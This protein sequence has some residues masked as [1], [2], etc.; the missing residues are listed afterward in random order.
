MTK[1]KNNAEAVWRGMAEEHDESLISVSGHR[2]RILLL[3]GSSGNRKH[4]AEHLK[5]RYQVFFP[6][7]ANPGDGLLQGNDAETSFDLAII[8]ATGALQWRQ[9]LIDARWRAQP[10]FLPVMLIASKSDLPRA[11]QHCGA[12]IDEF[13]IAPVDPGE[14]TQ[15]ANMLLRARRQALTQSDR[16]AY[17]TSHDQGS[18]LPNK[19]LFMDRLSQAI[20]DGTVLRRQVYAVVIHISL[21]PILKSLGNHA[22]ERAG[23][24]CSDRLRTLL[25][26]QHSLA[27]LATEEWGL[28]LRAGASTDD[29]LEVFR[30]IQKLG[31]TPILVDGERIHVSPTVGIAIYPDDAANASSLLDC[32]SAA[33]ART[34]Q[35]SRPAF[36]S[37]NVQRQALSHIRTE[38]GLH[39]ALAKEQFELWFQPKVSLEDRQPVGVEALV[40]WR[41]PSGEL[42]PPNNF[43]PVAEA[44]GLI[45]QIDRWVL[46]KACECLRDWRSRNESRPVQ[47]AVNISAQHLDAPDFVSTIKETLSR[48]GVPAEAIELELTET[49]LADLGP[50]NMT[51]LR[52]LRD[53]GVN[54]ALDDF[55]TGYCSLSYL[56][57]LPITTLKIDKCFIDNIASDSADAAIT[58]TI[59]S[60]AKNFKLKL[61]A[62][63]IET[64]EQLE[65]LAKLEVETG[66]GYLF[67][68][69]MPCGELQHWVRQAHSQTGKV[70]RGEGAR[71]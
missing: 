6:D 11:L 58:Q 23:L 52:V 32:A 45:A 10:V 70:R 8:D 66:Q 33:L 19:S 39:E 61:V 65:C 63:G 14:L 54:I 47:I 44:A 48:F 50:E 15:R 30:R 24:A 57:K 26:D 62:E 68:R 60:L 3:V 29:A 40:R 43:I 20:Q 51:K 22:L 38:A 37:R 12:H 59:V 13:L 69:P 21:A 64:E 1:K 55:G 4:L 67:A 17:L 46:T 35:A 28:M 36:Y 53:L 2:E 9:A 42:V 18:G 34:Q 7:E 16:L 5:S 27:R 31:S 49:A 71:Q 56:H 41:L 25:D